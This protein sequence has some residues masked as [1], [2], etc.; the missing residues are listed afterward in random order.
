MY[1]FQSNGVTVELTNVPFSPM[2]LFSW[3]VIFVS[4]VKLSGG[5]CKHLFLKLPMNSC[6]PISANTL[7]QNTVRIITSES[8]FTDWIRAPTIVF[9]PAK[10]KDFYYDVK[11]IL[12]TQKNHVIFPD[13]IKISCKMTTESN[14]C[15]TIIFMKSLIT[16][17]D[18]WKAVRLCLF[19]SVQK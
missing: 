3:E 16:G 5:H 9:K 4:K 18:E 2:V 10:R 7:R 1:P 6:S 14:I 12:N 19:Y 11:Q 8:F 13:K 15:D 17:E